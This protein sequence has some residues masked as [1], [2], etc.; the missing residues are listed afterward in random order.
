MSRKQ[1]CQGA[2]AVATQLVFGD[3]YE[4]Q[5]DIPKWTFPYSHFHDCEDLSDYDAVHYR[6]DV[7]DLGLE[8]TWERICK[9]MLVNGENNFLS[10][11]SLGELY[12]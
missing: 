12:E 9:W 11:G 5:I 1:F 10:V 2:C 4:Q 6:T 8:K 3:I 7:A